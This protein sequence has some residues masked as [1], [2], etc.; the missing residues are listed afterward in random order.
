LVSQVS[1]GDKGHQQS[2]AATIAGSNH[3]LQLNHN[4]TSPVVAE[5]SQRSRSILFI[6]YGILGATLLEKYQAGER[7]T[8]FLPENGFISLNIPLTPLRIGSLSTRTTHPFYLR[9]FQELLNLAGF[10]VDIENP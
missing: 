10:R 5:R 4:I 3:H 1:N 8:L 6:A 9:H 2:F 7:V